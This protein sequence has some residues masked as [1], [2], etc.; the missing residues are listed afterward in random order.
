MALK[1]ECAL[2]DEEPRDQNADTGLV[3]HGYWSLG[4]DAGES[5]SVTLVEQNEYLDV[6]FEWQWNGATEADVKR[7]AEGLEVAGIAPAR[8]GTYEIGSIP[9]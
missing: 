7:I 4:P 3:A 9:A 5:W 8:Y 6:T 1:W 2:H